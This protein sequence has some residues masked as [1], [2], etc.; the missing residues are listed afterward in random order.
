MVGQAHEV[1]DLDLLGPCVRAHAGV[2][3]WL[4]PS[5]GL[6]VTGVAQFISTGDYTDHGFRGPEGHAYESPRFLLRVSALFAA[7]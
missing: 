3:Y 7:W 5:F 1:G 4:R 2:D 6:S